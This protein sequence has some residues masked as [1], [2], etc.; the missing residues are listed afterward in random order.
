[1]NIL[2]I[3][4]ISLLT[5]HSALAGGPS[6]CPEYSAPICADG[7]KIVLETDSEGC[8]VPVCS[9]HGGELD[10]DRLWAEQS[11][12]GAKGAEENQE[13]F[14]SCVSQKLAERS[15]GGEVAKKN[16]KAFRKC[17]NQKSKG[18]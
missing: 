2:S 1:M 4:L 7:E 17:M 12:G 10:L 5:Q 16:K 18:K 13:E 14:D 8:Q 6:D 15:C 3:F 9:G 11:C